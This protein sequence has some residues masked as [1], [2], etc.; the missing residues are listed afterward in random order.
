MYAC[1]HNTRCRQTDSTSIS[2]AS[3]WLFRPGPST[4][5][6]FRAHT[7]WKPSTTSPKPSVVMNC[8]DSR[9]VGPGG[10]APRWIQKLDQEDAHLTNNNVYLSLLESIEVSVLFEQSPADV[11]TYFK[12]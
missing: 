7:S 12:D 5:P 10:V 9:G 4:G 11:I 1:M 8:V 2:G 6:S 3:C